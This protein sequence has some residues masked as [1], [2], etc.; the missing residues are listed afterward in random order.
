MPETTL[1]WP[2]QASPNRNR[3]T[4]SQGTNIKGHYVCE[5]ILNFGGHIEG[6]LTA[7]TLVIDQTG[8]VEGTIAARHLTIEGKVQGRIAAM[9]LTLKPTAI[10]NAKIICKSLVIE[11]GADVSGAVT[12]AVER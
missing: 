8:Q 12:K 1:T 11:S 2:R 3:S 6:D 5:G 4:L 7:D 10:V 9:N